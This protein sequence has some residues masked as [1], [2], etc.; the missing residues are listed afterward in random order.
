MG[1]VV[2]LPAFNKDVSIW[3]QVNIGHRQLNIIDYGQLAI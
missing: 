2:V 1:T 3:R